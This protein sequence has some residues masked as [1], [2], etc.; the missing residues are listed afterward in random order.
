MLNS[1]QHIDSMLHQ[2]EIHRFVYFL[3]L[4]KNIVIQTVDDAIISDD[5][6][7]TRDTVGDISYYKQEIMAADNFC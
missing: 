4:K 2:Y 5:E 3:Q 7:K 1:T 6:S